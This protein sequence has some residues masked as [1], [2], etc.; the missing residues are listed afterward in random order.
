[1]CPHCNL[2]GG[3][4]KELLCVLA[5]YLLFEFVLFPCFIAFSCVFNDNVCHFK[6]ALSVHSCE[7]TSCIEN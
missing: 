1:M 3:K 7:M 2:Q 4:K 5:T 6:A